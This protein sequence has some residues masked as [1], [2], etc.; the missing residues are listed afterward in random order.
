MEA[1]NASQDH[2]LEDC[3]KSSPEHPQHTF[4][5]D[6]IVGTEICTEKTGEISRIHCSSL[7]ICPLH[8]HKRS[9]QW[10][11][12][13]CNTIRKMHTNHTCH[14][15]WEHAK[16]VL[17]REVQSRFAIERSQK[18]MQ[19]P[20]S[21]SATVTSPFVLGLRVTLRKVQST[22]VTNGFR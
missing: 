11:S 18:G 3:T 2:H 15:P 16:D 10:I 1:W 5:C 22:R 12:N 20:W 21:Y 14:T 9:I 17:K 6:N 7:Q 4:S 19:A 8:P 13:L